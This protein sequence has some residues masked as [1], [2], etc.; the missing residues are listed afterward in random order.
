MRR[1]MHSSAE[2]A[3]SFSRPAGYSVAAT[4]TRLRMLASPPGATPWAQSHVHSPRSSSGLRVI[5]GMSSMVGGYM[6]TTAK[7]SASPSTCPSSVPTARPRMA[8]TNPCCI[9]VSCS[10]AISGKNSDTALPEVDMLS[11]GFFGQMSP[12]LA[13]RQGG[14]TQGLTSRGAAS[15]PPQS[16]LSPLSAAPPRTAPPPSSAAALG[17]RPCPHHRTR[18]RTAANAAR[19]RT[20]TSV[21]PPWLGGVT[22]SRT[23]QGAAAPPPPRG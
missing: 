13:P 15:P 20:A 1:S 21:R 19:I 5:S 4:R 17:R 16:P 9:S 7:R 3:A 22:L 6:S 2:T 12:L 11:S 14:A 10:I 8:V 18:P 23:R